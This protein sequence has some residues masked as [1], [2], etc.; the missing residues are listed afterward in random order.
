MKRLDNSLKNMVL[1]LT[2]VSVVAA[3]MLGGMYVLTK[4]PI[5]IAQQLKQDAAKT[6]VLPEAENLIFTLIQDEDEVEVYE[7][8]SG[9]ELIGYAVKTY[10]TNGFNGKFT[11]MVGFNPQKD[12]T[13]Y[14]VLEQNETPGLG[15]NMV[16]WFK[17]EKGKQSIIGLNPATSTF[18]VTKDGGDVDAITAATITSRAFMRAVQLAYDK[19]QQ[20]SIASETIELP[21]DSVATIE[22]EET[23]IETANP[24]DNE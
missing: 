3:A 24:Q 20:M 14:T 10:D 12:I 17:T 11:I 9:E 5:S 13:G 16:Q 19:L 15:A 8:T 4:E 1:S 18:K 23:E 21:T 22:V 6:E 2:I 7:A